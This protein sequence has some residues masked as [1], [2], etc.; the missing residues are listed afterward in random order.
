MMVINIL[1]EEGVVGKTGCQHSI[2]FLNQYKD[3]INIP[4]LVNVILRSPNLSWDIELA[5]YIEL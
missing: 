2:S 3:K 4:Q 1:Y 5:F